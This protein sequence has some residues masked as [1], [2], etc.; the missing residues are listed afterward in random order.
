MWVVVCI[1]SGEEV[2]NADDSLSGKFCKTVI[3]R[4]DSF[5][6][7]IVSNI[8]DELNI[9]D[10]V[11][12]AKPFLNGSDL[13][14]SEKN[15]KRIEKHIKGMFG[16]QAS[17]LLVEFRQFVIAFIK[18]LHSLSE[19]LEFKLVINLS[20]FVHPIHFIFITYLTILFDN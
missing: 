6:R 19:Q 7:N 1:E 4:G 15:S 3:N 5:V 14:R 13:L 16:H 11:V 10:P 12:F 20:D 9:V 18:V 17:I 8:L 2:L